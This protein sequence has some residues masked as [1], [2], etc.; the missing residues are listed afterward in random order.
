MLILCACTRVSSS[1]DPTT[2]LPPSD[3]PSS[4]T[5]APAGSAAAPEPTGVPGLTASDPLC[6]AWAGYVG[7]V[8]AL[9]VAASFGDLSSAQLAALELTS[10]PYLAEVAVTIDKSWPVELASER[11]TVID[12]R[13]GPYARRAARGDDALVQAGMTTAELSELRSSWQ[14]AL[15]T[16]D[17]RSPVLAV[18]PVSA[19]VQAKLDAATTVYDSAATPFAQDP[20][21]VVEAVDA[22]LTDAY[23]AAHCPD[24]AA[25]GVGD[26]L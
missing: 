19:Q 26:A 22:P 13:I 25:S 21:L 11:A 1:A 4:A 2:S 24:L 15:A 14:S 18:A 20:S 12:Q 16:Q 23:L 17:P 6:A 7:T 8:Q 10:A 9:G 3:L 5:N